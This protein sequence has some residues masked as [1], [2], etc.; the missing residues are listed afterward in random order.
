[1]N[2]SHLNVVQCEDDEKFTAV[3]EDLLLEQVSNEMSK[4]F[5]LHLHC[6]HFRKSILYQNLSKLFRNVYV[7]EICDQAL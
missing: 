7:I 3:R 1:M 5:P 4:A 6:I 2:I